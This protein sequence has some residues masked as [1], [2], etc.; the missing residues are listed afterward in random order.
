MALRIDRKS[1]VVV[2][3]IVDMG[4]ADINTDDTTDDQ[5]AALVSC[6]N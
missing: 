4:Y 5:Y 3:D 2:D 6:T 1:V